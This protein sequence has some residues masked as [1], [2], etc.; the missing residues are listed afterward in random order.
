MPAA[1]TGIFTLRPSFGRFTTQRCRSGLAGQEAV[2]SVNGPMGKTLED[3]TMY[4]KAI[5]DAKPWLV[6]PKMLPIPWRI[7]EPKKKLKIAVLWNDGICA[8]T[9]PVTRALQETAEKLKK[10]GH[11][12]I[13]WDPKLHPTALTLLVRSTLMKPGS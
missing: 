6:D 1:C 13:D 7:Q 2:Q 5:V 8:P 10:A 12:I 11:E 3:I 9:P 4:S